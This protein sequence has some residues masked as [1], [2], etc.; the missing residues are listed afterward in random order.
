MTQCA[1][2]WYETTFVAKPYVRDKLVVAVRPYFHAYLIFVSR[3]FF[4]NS[5]CKDSSK[6]LLKATVIK[7]LAR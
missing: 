4:L 1:T 5:L 2:T 7:N 3:Y 6:I